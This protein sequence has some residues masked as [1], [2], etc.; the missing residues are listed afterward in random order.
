MVPVLWSSKCEPKS[1]PPPDIILN[2]HF[3]A[4]RDMLFHLRTRMV[5]GYSKLERSRV[6]HRIL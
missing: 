6:F 4:R 2:I 5:L 1:S 3:V